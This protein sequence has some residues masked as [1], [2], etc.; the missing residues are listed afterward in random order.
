MTAAPALRR[1]VVVGNGVAGLTAADSL[2]AGGFDGELTIIG[3]EARAAYSRPAL[4]KAL[5][6]SDADLDAHLL[7]APDHGA[8]ELLGVA[9]AGLDVE[10]RRLSLDDGSALEYD[11][12]VIA[13]G[14][15][16]RRLG[17][18]D[19]ELVLRTLD[20]AHLLRARLV[21]RPDLVIVGGGPLGMEVASGALEAGCRVTLVTNAPPMARHLGAHLGERI[22]RAALAHALKVVLTGAARVVERG[23]RSVVELADGSAVDGDL[24]VSAVGD[25]PSTDW[26]LGSGLPMLG[27]ALAVDSRGRLR[28]EI[29]AAGD[30]AAVPTPIGH[31]RSPLWNSAIE[32]ARIGAAALLHGDEA[33]ELRAQPYFWTEQ[34]GLNIRVA[35]P[36][37]LIGEPEV[38][39]GGA[40]DAPA[41]LRWRHPGGTGTAVSVNFRIPIPRLRRLGDAPAAADC[42]CCGTVDR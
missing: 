15:R 36:T 4:S 40:A 13:S 42:Q 2:R 24:V 10:R 25:I 37:P 20:D 18:L 12:L 23:G 14:S 30:V 7:P 9:A 32:Q 1:I 16:A 38:L 22:L 8:T 33:A 26:L 6:R 27:H 21:D 39:E 19:D 41:L 34:F 5:L 29:V 31:A 35:G 28:D 3:A 17:S 11:G